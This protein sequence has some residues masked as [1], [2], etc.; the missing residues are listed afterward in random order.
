MADDG[1]KGRDV[2]YHLGDVTLESDDG[3]PDHWHLYV[4]DEG[5]DEL[6]TVGCVEQLDHDYLM[7]I[8]Q[9]VGE[10]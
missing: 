5:R 4:Y 10:A 9:S 3:N 8:T 2:V 7:S 1:R 6:V